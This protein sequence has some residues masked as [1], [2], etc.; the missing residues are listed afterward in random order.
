MRKLWSLLVA[1][2][3]VGSLVGCQSDAGSGVA[4]SGS[5]G[6]ASAS[7]EGFPRTVEHAMGKTEIPA[8][9]VRVVAL[10]QTFV[11]ATLSLQ[12][13]LVGY[14]QIA[15]MP[16]GQ[17]PD[18]LGDTMQ[19]AKSAVSVGTLEEPSLEK[20]AELKPDLI[21]SAKIRHETLYQQLSQI[22][23]T[24]FSESTGAVWK[25]NLSLVAEAT[26]QEDLAEELLQGFE[27]RAAK[28]GENIAADRGELPTISI[29]RFSGGGTIRCYIEDSY[30]GVVLKD[31]GFTRPEGQ[32]SESDTVFVEISQENIPQLDAEVIFV[33]TWADDEATKDRDKITANPL[34]K[35]LKGQTYEV[36]DTIWMTAVGLQGAHALLDDL[37][38]QF[39]V[40]P[41]SDLR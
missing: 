37:A 20:I 10:D 18:Y 2:I 9:P 6:A 26:G 3:L 5:S 32:P 7:G 36:D 39:E 30:S 34:W 35:T 41:A 24:V 8:R 25:E 19:Y 27:Q 21:V 33:S 15:D 22:A 16:D 29:A 1:V 12:T 31:V 14:T 13:E 17:L 11:D 23:P 38:G 4:G 40:D 28:I